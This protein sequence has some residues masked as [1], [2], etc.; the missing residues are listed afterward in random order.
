MDPPLSPPRISISDRRQ[1]VPLLLSSFPAPPTHI[2]LGPLTPLSPSP[3]FLPPASPNLAFINPPLSA[4]PATP[5][6][7]VPGPSPISEHDTLMFMSAARTRRASRISLAS[8]S[9]RYST[10]SVVSGSHSHQP[11]PPP[12]SPSVS[13]AS[14]DASNRS[15][16]SFDSSGSLSF[17]TTRGTKSSSSLKEPRI[18]EEDSADLTRMSL[19]EMEMSMSII[20]GMSTHGH[21][22]EMD[23]ETELELGLSEAE[24]DGESLVEFGLQPSLSKRGK[25]PAHR[26][27]GPNDSISSIDMRD[28]PALEEEDQE[29][30]FPMPPPLPPSLARFDRTRNPGFSPASPQPSPSPIVRQFSMRKLNKDLPPLPSASSSKQTIYE[31]DDR[32]ASPDIRTILE[33]TPKP[34][35]KSASSLNASMRSRSNSRPRRSSTRTKAPRRRVSEPQVT[36]GSASTTSITITVDSHNGRR[37]DV[38][39]RSELPY[40]HNDRD[41]QNRHE[42]S[43][44]YRGRRRVDGDGDNSDDSDYGV[45]IDRTGTEIELFDRDLEDRLE[46]QLEGDGSDS[47]SDIDLHTPLPYVFPLIILLLQISVHVLTN[48]HFNFLLQCT[49]GI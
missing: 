49:T 14:L 46:S 28:L 7:P 45:A 33:S 31:E 44:I 43:R 47:D 18:R 9:S 36:S 15:L 41:T 29:D 19:E 30:D 42:A 6:P 5:L 13:S 40:A 20:S 4:P 21:G 11:H 12:L 32:S 10:A 16:R 22:A 35:R 3:G 24:E 37:S 1:A 17:P 34:R 38:I 27:H 2:P 25:R 23:L 8:S 26:D 39:V 48:L